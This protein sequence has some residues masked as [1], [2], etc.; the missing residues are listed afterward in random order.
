MISLGAHPLGQSMRHQ[1]RYI[2]IILGIESSCDDIRGAHESR[3][4]GFEILAEK[5]A[6]QIEVHKNTAVWCRKLRTMPCRKHRTTNPR[7][8]RIRTNHQARRYR[9]DKWAWFDN[10]IDGWGGSGELS[11]LWNTPIVSIST[12]RVIYTVK[13]QIPNYKFQIFKYQISNTR[14]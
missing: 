6:S 2:M 10:W 9:C 3:R 14:H 8:A 12:L 13:L 7:S 4:G 11:Y 5:T 1:F